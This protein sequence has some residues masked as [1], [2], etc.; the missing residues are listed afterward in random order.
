MKKIIGIFCLLLSA[1][2]LHAEQNK[3]TFSQALA[4]YNN[5]INA[6]KL[7]QSRHP[8]HL[9]TYADPDGMRLRKILNPDRYE[10]TLITAQANTGDTQKMTQFTHS[11]L[12]LIDTMYIDAFTK[13]WGTYDQEYLDI[14]D[15][16]LRAFKLEWR[17]LAP[18]LNPRK[19]TAEDRAQVQ[20]L[21]NQ[22]ESMI[23]E[24]SNHIQKRRFSAAYKAQAM[25]RLAM[26]KGMVQ[27]IKPKI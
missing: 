6:Y 21:F 4:A 11:Q 12:D 19:M 23:A 17:Q 20:Q 26:L 9:M 18:K 3:E 24:L 10:A 25:A 1:N 15:M 27:A 5:D 8:A 16:K 13:Q 22:P 7:A 2:G 14:Q